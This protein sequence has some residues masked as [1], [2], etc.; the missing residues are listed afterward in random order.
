LHVVVGL[1][2]ARTFPL[3]DW[4]DEP[5]HFNYVRRLADGEGLDVMSADAWAPARLEELKRQHFRGLTGPEDPRIA[6]IRYE[7]HQPPVYYAAASLVYRLTHSAPALKAFNLALSCLGILLAWLVARAVF[8]GAPEVA[9]GSALLLALLPMR[10]FTAVSIGND[11]ASECVFALAVLAMLKR[12]RPGLV[13]LVI[14][15]GLL[16]KIHLLLLLPLY[17]AW[18]ALD[19]PDREPW[20]RRILGPA[21]LRPLLVAGAVALV[22][23]SPWILRNMR[24]YGWS[25]P[26]ALHA[27][28][29]GSREAV[30]AELGA[31]RPTLQ[32]TGA[33]GVARFVWILFQSWWGV[34]GW[35]GFFMPARVWV[36]FALLTS[37]VAAGL[38]RY[39]ADPNRAERSARR[40]G[41][42]LWLG[43]GVALVGLA[44]MVY[45][46]GDFQ[47]QGRYLLVASCGSG[48][49]F[50][51]GVRCLA[52]RRAGVVLA[53][54]S[55][56]LLAI[57][58][59]SALVFVP[60]YLPPP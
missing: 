6:P 48:L 49:L 47:A 60:R 30:A 22:V 59:Y 27:G 3:F 26:L 43:A 37:M 15:M 16:T 19:A 1:L 14:G 50:G 8:P 56:V 42:V 57:N 58:L 36:W 32:W 54:S 33:F 38:A 45:S 5:A 17:A 23:A 52:G 4:P 46:L 34:F 25:D 7:A 24:L 29:L 2:Y 51:L 53:L 41:T 55:V 9:A 13:G 21:V 31:P 44:L 20:P 10:A 11:P 12:A 28:A 40:G 18:L 39:A 35:M